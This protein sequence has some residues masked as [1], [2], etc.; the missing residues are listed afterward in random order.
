MPDGP[1]ALVAVEIDGG[2]N[3]SLLPFNG[4]GETGLVAVFEQDDPA[5]FPGDPEAT[6]FGNHGLEVRAID[7]HIYAV[8][9]RTGTMGAWQINADGSL[10]ALTPVGGLE[11]GVDPFV[12]TNPGIND[13]KERCFNQPEG[14]R[15]PECSL[16]S[17]QGIAGF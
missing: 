16:G 15:D 4:L 12:G 7:G 1:G 9:P 10:D 2:G 14:D 3:L 6:V 13:F 11:V 5:A 8:Q 17:A